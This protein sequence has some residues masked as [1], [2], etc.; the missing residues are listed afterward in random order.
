MEQLVPIYESAF[1]KF[2][3]PLQYSRDVNEFEVRGFIN[4]R[5][6]TA[7]STVVNDYD[8]TNMVVVLLA[9]DL[10]SNGVYPPKKFDKVL[11]DGIKRNVEVER[12]NFVHTTPVFIR[13][14]VTG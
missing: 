13:L 8:A 9:K 12:I 2:A 14:M 10:I 5:V 7:D 1:L 11:V 6:G 4:F 3:R